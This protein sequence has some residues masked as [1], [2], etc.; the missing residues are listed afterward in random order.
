MAEGSLVKT[1]EKC[2]LCGG[3]LRYIGG[4]EYKCIK[5]YRTQM[6]D[7]GKVR[8]YLYKHGNASMKEIAA[9]TGV[10]EELLVELLR[11]G[12]LEMRGDSPFKISCEMCGRQISSGRICEKCQKYIDEI[13]HYRD[14]KYN[15]KQPRIKRGAVVRNVQNGRMRYINQ[16]DKK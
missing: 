15:P 10:S 9:S 7:Y 12:K 16:D 8:D 5:C 4:G 1:L 14:E 3:R 13:Q 11:L 2:P 6:D